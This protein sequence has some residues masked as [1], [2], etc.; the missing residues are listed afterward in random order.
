MH[1]PSHEPARIGLAGFGN[2]GQYLARALDSG[3]LPHARLTAVTARDLDRAARNAEALTS[4]PAIVPLEELCAH[5]D[6]VVECATAGALPE[7]ARAV[8]GRGRQLVLVSAGGMPAFPD[9]V[10][11]A[12]R[13]GGRIRIASGALPGLDSVRGAAEG[14]LCS[15]R[16][17]S[18]IKP[19]SFIGE[20][21]L[22]ARGLDF[23]EPPREAVQVFSGSA[24]EAALAF[25]R[26][27][28]VA[29]ALSLA[30]LGLERTM[31]E[32]WAD[33]DIPGAQHLVEV[34]AEEIVLT[35]RSQNFPSPTNPK[36]SRAVGPSILAALRSM[37]ATLQVGS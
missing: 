7:I 3:A 4:R 30:G 18:R 11:F 32:I 34:E 23:S 12:E 13:H 31:V 20:P 14:T 16:L 19:N 2:V 28:N 1:N 5:A 17:T 9:M 35:M 33:P 25:P 36:T 10:D 6:I 27:F 37:T 24:R 22:E 26:H 29:I 8:L 21:Y 15:V